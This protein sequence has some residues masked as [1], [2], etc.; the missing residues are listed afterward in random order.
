MGKHFKIKKSI[1][2]NSSK[3][4]LGLIGAAAA[5]IA[6][7]MLMAPDKGTEIRKKIS[8]TVGD[9]TSRAGDLVSY[10]KDKLEQVTNT[11]TKQADG[12]Y[13]DVSKRADKVKENAAHV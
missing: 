5:G 9:L 12:L 3:V 6:I 13:Q 7:G 11:V 4:I 1:M 2:E 10:G 8:D